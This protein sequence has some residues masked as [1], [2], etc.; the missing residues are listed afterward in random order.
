MRVVC[1]GSRNFEGPWAVQV[2]GE[3]LHVAWDLSVRFHQPFTVVHGD[4]ATGAD[5]VV[6]LWGTRRTDSGVE[7]VRFPADWRLYGK[8]AG[9]R[10]NE[11]MIKA[12]GDLC[13]GFVRD[14]ST[15]TTSTLRLAREAGIA[16]FSIDWN[17]QW[18]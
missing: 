5:R 2:I 1:T 10:R 9:P 14:N 13:F 6:D 17:D 18:L 16:T 3:I 4:C 12:G 11:A 15:G 7:V 8:A